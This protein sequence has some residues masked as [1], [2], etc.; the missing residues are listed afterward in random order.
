MAALQ[1]SV[2]GE[3]YL[4]S[5]APT[6]GWNPSPDIYVLP[7]GL[8]M[9]PTWP[10][11]HPPTGHLPSSPCLPLSP[12]TSA[13]IFCAQY[14]WLC[15][16]GRFFF[17]C[18]NFPKGKS[19]LFSDGSNGTQQKLVRL[20]ILPFL[21]SPLLSPLADRYL[22]SFG[23]CPVWSFQGTKLIPSKSSEPILESRQQ[24]QRYV[25]VSSLMAL[26][27]VLVWTSLYTQWARRHR[28][29]PSTQNIQE[30]L[31]TWHTR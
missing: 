29:C 26:L 12:V 28:G 13:F 21:G 14:S 31:A 22:G 11:C 27:G 25:S 4:N 7:L 17:L 2:T 16:L 20:S 8:L 30:L 23:L 3:F 24:G 1:V 18:C 9:A 19:W 6:T 5:P 15:P 10:R